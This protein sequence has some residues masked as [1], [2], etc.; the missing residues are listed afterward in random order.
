M[1][2][3]L[4]GKFN[5]SIILTSKSEKDIFYVLSINNTG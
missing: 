5:I 3:K 4:Q 1:S 2:K